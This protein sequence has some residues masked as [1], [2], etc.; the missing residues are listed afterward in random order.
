M[1]LIPVT[2]VKE[3][4]GA[5]AVP[6]VALTGADTLAAPGNNLQTLV[7]QND[8]ASSATIVV[9]GDGATAFN[10]GGIGKTVDLSAGYSIVVPA[11]ESRAV[12]LANIVRYLVGTINV[13][14]GS[15]DVKAAVIQ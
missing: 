5:I 12:S 2:K 9:D 15:A 7:L 10:P 8:G 14:G 1:A 13:T 6:F 4:V 11:G 3:A